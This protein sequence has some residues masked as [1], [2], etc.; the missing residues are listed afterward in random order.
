MLRSNDRVKREISQDIH[1]LPFLSYGSLFGRLLILSSWD[2][3]V[4][5]TIRELSF[6]SINSLQ[7]DASGFPLADKAAFPVAQDVRVDK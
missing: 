6:H 7:T 5:S 3:D 4:R 2:A 1:H